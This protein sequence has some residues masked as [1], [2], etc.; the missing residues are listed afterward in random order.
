MKLNIDKEAIGKVAKGCASFA[1]FTIAMILPHVTEKNVATM[2]HYIGKADYS[3]AVSAIMGSD[4]FGSYKN[5]I[6]DLLKRD[7]TAEYYGAII[8][9]INSDMFGSYKVDAIR[10]INEK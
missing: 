5:E 6:M 1:V 3:D 10:K 2:K 9:I 4:M 7:E 8:E